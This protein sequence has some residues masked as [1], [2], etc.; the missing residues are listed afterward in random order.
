MLKIIVS[1]LIR[2]FE[3]VVKKKGVLNCISNNIKF[4]VTLD[5]TK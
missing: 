5:F 1:F 2:Y 3:N 4:D